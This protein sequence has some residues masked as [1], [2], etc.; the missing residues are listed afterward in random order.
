MTPSVRNWPE[1]LRN[2]RRLMRNNFA[3]YHKMIKYTVYDLIH[4]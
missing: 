3:E 4:F 2:L 1:Q